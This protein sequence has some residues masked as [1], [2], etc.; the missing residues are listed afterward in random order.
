V[1]PVFDIGASFDVAFDNADEDTGDYE[2]GDGEDTVEA[3]RT[4]IA[5]LEDEKQLILQV[6]CSRS[7][8]AV[9]QD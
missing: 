1:P 2:S 3:L 9:A 8:C 6:R 5:Q 4:Y 7:M